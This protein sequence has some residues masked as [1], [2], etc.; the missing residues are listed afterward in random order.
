VD[1]EQR[2]IRLVAPKTR[3]Y[4]EV[5]ICGRLVQILT[6]AFNAARPGSFSV[7]GLSGHNLYRQAERYCKAAGL[8]KWPNFF[9]SM[10]S[11]CENDWKVKGLAEPTYTTWLG[12]SAKVSREHYVAPTDAE[13]AVVINAA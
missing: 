6:E 9:Q 10:R 7:S 13:F 5:P 11:S 12:H 4:R 1:W 2:R 8:R 3:T